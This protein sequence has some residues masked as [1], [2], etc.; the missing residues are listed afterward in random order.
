MAIRE[1]EPTFADARLVSLKTKKSDGLF[2][3]IEDFREHI[4]LQQLHQSSKGETLS[5][6]ATKPGTSFRGQEALTPP[7]SSLCGDT[8]WL[9]D[10]VY[11]VPE[12]RTQE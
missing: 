8:H 11:L 6:F 12:N 4:R 5:A 7:K 1:K 9:A 2:E 3:M 10:C